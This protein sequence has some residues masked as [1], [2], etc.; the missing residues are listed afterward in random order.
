MRREH[1]A[2]P[3]PEGAE[4]RTVALTVGGVMRTV[5]AVH[6]HRGVPEGRLEIIGR[7]FLLMGRGGFHFL[8]IRESAVPSDAL[9]LVSG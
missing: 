8:G 1:R 6:H 4:P 2:G 3:H 7:P 9:I 5:P